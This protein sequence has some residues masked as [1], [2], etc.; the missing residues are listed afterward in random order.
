MQHAFVNSE[1]IQS[2]CSPHP[3]NR[4]H[5]SVLTYGKLAAVV[6]RAA[7]HHLTV[8]PL[9]QNIPTFQR[10]CV[11]GQMEFLSQYI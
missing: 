9:Y 3:W 6:D 10:L 7:A 2:L 4:P 5:Y 11:E 8:S 1:C